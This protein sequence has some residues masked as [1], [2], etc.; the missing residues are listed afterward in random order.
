MKTAPRISESE[1]EVMKILWEESPLTANQVITRLSHTD[2]N[3][4]TIR[5]LLSRLV[6]KKAAK[7]QSDG[8]HYVFFARISR[9]DCIRHE[10]EGFLERVFNGEASPLLAHFVQYTNLPA[11]EIQK[12]RSILEKKATS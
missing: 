10:S 3:H 6:R 7:F 9:E 5:T 2:W 11:R 1:W 12:L 4:R 8:N